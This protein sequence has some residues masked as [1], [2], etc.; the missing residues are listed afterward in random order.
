M[1][2]EY[3]P[4]NPHEQQSLIRGFGNHQEFAAESLRIRAKSGAMV[5]L[6]LQPAQTKLMNAVNRQRRAGL[7]VR[8]CYLKAGQVMVSSATAAQNFH[9]V[10][11]M[12][13]RACL[14][15]ADSEDHSKLVFG[16]YKGYQDNYVPYTGGIYEAGVMLPDLIN[17]RDDT[18]KY[19]ND[20]FIR[21]VTGKNVHAGRSHPWHAVQVSEFGFM[22]SGATFMDGTMQRVPNHPETI[23][24]VESTGFGEGGPFYE[25]CQRAQDP[26]RAGGWLFVFFGWH[27]HPEYSIPVSDPAAF[28]RDLS[29][30]EKE[31]RQRYGLTLQQ[32]AWRRWCIVNNCENRVEVFRQEF[33][34]NPR[35]AFQSS[36]RTYLDLRAVERCSAIEEPMR[37]QL[38]RVQL[39]G[40][41]RI[42]F[43]QKDNFPL[44][45]YRRPKRLGRYVIGADAAQGK[46]PEVKKGGRTNPDYAAATVRDADTGEQVAAYQARVTEGLFGKVIYELG[47]FYNWAFIVPETTGHGRA[48]L[49]SL[50]EE[51]YPID[52]IYTKQRPPDDRRPVT[53]NELGYET[54]EVTR[55][56]LL[57]A[58]DTAILEGSITIHHGATTQELRTLV[59]NPDGKVAAK[60]GAHDDLAFSEALSVVGL[61]FAPV[62]PRQTEEERR[63]QWKPVKYGR[64][65]DS[66]D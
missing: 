37:G 5:P 18:L 14:A 7:P 46:D 13:G 17:D 35:E 21:C 20:S 30:E 66:D 2:P 15:V 24:I 38:E 3:Q 51:N 53:F 9:F 25:L 16:Y 49:Q 55:P 60:L 27:E 26:T 39:A 1:T 31:E 64:G 48:F 45:I 6:I 65:R 4:L 54:N 22:D 40:D 44:C 58:L 63:K 23:V 47:W 32:L 11:F 33:P 42:T 28:Q 59:S 12:P 34:S 57:S 19:A 61:R 36:S 52:L 41:T 56:V 29:I 8:I 10:P 50:L 43:V 62:Q